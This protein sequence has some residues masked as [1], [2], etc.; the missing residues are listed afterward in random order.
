[1]AS[2]VKLFDNQRG[3]LI[4]KTTKYPVEHLHAK[5][6]FFRDRRPELYG[7]WLTK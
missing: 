1:M 6:L 2:P 3:G 5:R 7:E 4:W